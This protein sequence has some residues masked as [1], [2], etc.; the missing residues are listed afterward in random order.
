MLMYG[1]G[2]FTQTQLWSYFYK[3][4]LILISFCICKRE[5]QER[6]MHNTIIRDKKRLQEV[7]IQI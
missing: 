6:Y 4:L 3:L 1:I 7:W 2:T 5:S